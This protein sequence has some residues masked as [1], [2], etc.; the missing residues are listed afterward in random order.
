MLEQMGAADNFLYG[1]QEEARSKKIIR[2]T[3]AKKRNKNFLSSIK[4]D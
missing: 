1:I 2:K 4:E 3:K